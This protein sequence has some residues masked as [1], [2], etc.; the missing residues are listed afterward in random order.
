MK[1]LKFILLFT[2]STMSCQQEKLNI[3]VLSSQ[4]LD[5]VPSASGIVKSGD[6]YYLIG[7]DSPFLFSINSDFEFISKSPIYSIKNLQGE[8]IRK[9]DKPD[10][11]A[12]EVIS[13]NEIIVFGSGS[14][15]PQRDI[16]LRISLDKMPN[17][18]TYNISYF[19]D[20]LRKLK[21]LENHEL[22]IEAIAFHNDQ[23]YLFNRGRNVIFSFSYKK[24]MEHF[25]GLIPF[26]NPKTTLFDLPKING[27]EAGFSGA[28]VFQDKPFIIFT[29]S[30][31][32]TDNAYNDGEI[33]GSF[34]GIIDIINN[35]ISN[36]FK[37]AS[38]PNQVTPL[39][40]ESVTV[41]NETSE[42]ET[43]VILVTDSD[44]GKSMILKC[45][46]KW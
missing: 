44:G 14:K 7:D 13:E 27:I 30:V 11:E 1:Y 10:F 41:D 24:L 4:I 21:I 43:S 12:L 45:Q 37:S 36:L 8:T 26:P 9:E 28:T 2:V 29:A 35:D 31:E 38:I 39:K 6:N 15:S 46:L 22:N 32:N 19:Y 20:N 25:E 5:G 33:L 3:E 34:I 23:I 17:V 18:K 16:C 40:V 42:R